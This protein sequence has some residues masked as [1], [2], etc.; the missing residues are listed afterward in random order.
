MAVR[1]EIVVL[2][3]DGKGNFSQGKP[4]PYPGNSG[5]HVMT[6]G[7]D[8]DGTRYLLAGGSRALVLYREL[9]DAPGGFENVMLP[10]ATWP[11]WV[12]L[13]DIDGDGW[14]DAVA[15]IQGNAPSPVIY[16]PLWETFTAL[17]ASKAN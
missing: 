1:Q 16:G 8:R 17:V 5:I 15:A 14:L 9:K 3:N 4:V 7:Q 6:A 10:L 12:E 13:K 11:N 2:L